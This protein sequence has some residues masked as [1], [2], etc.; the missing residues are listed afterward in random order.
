MTKLRGV[1]RR[2]RGQG[3]RFTQLDWVR[4]QFRDKLGFEPYPGTLNV[5]VDNRA[6]RAAA[7][8]PPGILIEPA[9]AEYCAAKCL[10]VRINGRVD[11]AWIMPDV[12]NYP[13][14]LVELMA[15]IALREELGLE[16]GDAVSIEIS[17]Q[18]ENIN[19]ED[20]KTP[21]F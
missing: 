5:Q 19:R 11:A 3:S 7:Q 12:S 9:T 20:A 18:V 4:E 2:G 15:P 14:D 10:R 17:E 1:V 21:R 16:E 8:S 13:D 6:A